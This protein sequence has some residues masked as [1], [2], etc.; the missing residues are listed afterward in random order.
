MSRENVGV[1]RRSMEAFARGDEVAFL[2]EF[3]SEVVIQQTAPIPDARAYRG[4][5]GL[6][7]VIADWKEVFDGLVMS[8]EELTD[9]GADKVLV[10]VHQRAQGAGVESRSSSIP[11]T[12][13]ASSAARFLS[14]RC[15]TTGTTP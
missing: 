6:M 8:A 12:S 3:S 11:G 14:S 13:T 2:D 15:L 4:H 10:S 7:Q 1:V 9:C 5:E